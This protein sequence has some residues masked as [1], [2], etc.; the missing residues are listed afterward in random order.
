MSKQAYKIAL[1]SKWRIY[2]VFHISL[3]EQK[4]TRIR[5]VEPAME[6]RATTRSMRLKRFII[7]KSVLKN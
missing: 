5:V 3:L 2:D 6:S 4:I 7:L 1:P